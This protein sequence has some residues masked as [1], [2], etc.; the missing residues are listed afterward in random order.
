MLS[1]NGHSQPAYNTEWWSRK[2]MSGNVETQFDRNSWFSSS[3][4]ATP[5]TPNSEFGIPL[6][7]EKK[8]TAFDHVGGCRS[9]YKIRAWLAELL[10][11]WFCWI[12]CR[13]FRWVCCMM[14]GGLFLDAGSFEDMAQLLPSSASFLSHLE[15]ER[16][17]LCCS[18]IGFVSFF[19]GFVRHFHRPEERVSVCVCCS[20]WLWDARLF[21]VVM[22]CSLWGKGF[23]V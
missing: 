17:V 1:G 3:K 12:S 22:L 18:I 14:R 19:G 8:P 13:W 21:D 7:L 10:D 15:S 20:V 6:I 16:M 5:W 23:G 2:K 11:S 9:V 4:S